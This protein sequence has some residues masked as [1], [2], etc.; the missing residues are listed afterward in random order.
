MMKIQYNADK[1]IRGE[2]RHEQ[3]FISLISKELVRFQSQITRIEVHVSDENGKKGGVNDI[4]CLIEARVENKNPTAVSAQAD[5]LEQA[6]SDAIEKLK[7]VL[8]T[9]FGKSKNKQ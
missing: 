8:E 2:D 6:V 9:L 3:Y 4:R 1:T 5:T 7:T